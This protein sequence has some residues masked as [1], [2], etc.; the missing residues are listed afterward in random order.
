[1]P[2]QPRTFEQILADMTAYVL[3]NT[4][5]TDMNVGSVIRTILEAA[6]L[7]DDEQYFQMVQ[8]LDAF[9]IGT[10]VGPDLD[11]RL[12]DYDLIRLPARSATGTITVQNE[13]LV[14]STLLLAANPGDGTVSLASSAGFPNSGTVRLNEGTGSEEDVQYTSNNVATGIL[15]INPAT[16]ITN[17]QAVGTRASFVS[18]AADITLAAGIQ[19]RAPGTATQEAVNVITTA[20]VVLQDGDYES[21]PAAARATQ[22]GTDGNVRE[23]AVNEFAGAP[24]FGGAT[25]TSSQ[26]SGGRD[27]ETD[28]A[29]RDRGIQRIQG[30]AR[31][32]IAAI[33]SAA[34]GVESGD[35]RVETARVVEH[36]APADPWVALYVW[37]VVNGFVTEADIQHEV[38]TADSEDGQR[39]FRLAQYPVE[40]SSLLLYRTVGPGAPILLQED[41]DY[42]F[43]EGTG[44]IEILGGGLAEHDVLEAGQAAGPLAGYTYYTGLIAAVHR[45]IDGDPN[46]RTTYPG[47][48]AAGI[49][50]LVLS[51]TLRSLDTIRVSISVLP[52]FFEEDVGPVVENTIINYILGLGV[53]NDVIAAEAI[54]R[55]MGVDGMFDMSLEY[56]GLPMANIS[57]GEDQV[58]NPDT[59]DI[60]V[61]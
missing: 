17:V 14:R 52:G 9:A 5:L 30:L 20:S 45:V 16:P 31:A 21:P 29:F 23:G 18:G 40:E 33:E 8:L 59:L 27:R 12:A 22:A 60:V 37:P 58:I 2:F 61:S 49:K 19:A 24:P 44:W 53:G 6:A 1:M 46:D 56:N 11:E 7:E 57:I 13:N 36:F 54:E 42:A 38:L 50:V 28:D 34:V 3:A 35:F 47:V 15:T 51:P 41:V 43:N 4:D 32:T 25:V 48:R 55:G 10:A 26:F 39:F